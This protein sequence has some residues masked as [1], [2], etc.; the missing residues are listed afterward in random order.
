[1][2]MKRRLENW[3]VWTVVNLISVP[4]YFSRELYLS[5]ALYAFC[6]VNA[7]VSWRHWLDLY[8]DQNITKAERLIG[9][10]SE[11]WSRT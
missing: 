8:D 2:L 10:E 6:L 7:V 5:G 9:S 1:M 3:P 11:P 4:L